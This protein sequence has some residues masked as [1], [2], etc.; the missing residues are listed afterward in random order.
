MGTYYIDTSS[1]SM[2]LDA[3]EANPTAENG[4]FTN[5]QKGDDFILVTAI[6]Y[7]TCN[8]TTVACSFKLQFSKNG[9]AWTD[10][11]AATEISY[12]ADTTLVDGADSVQRVTTNVNS[13][14]TSGY[15]VGRES[16]GDNVVVAFATTLRYH[17]DIH[18]ALST[19]N[20]TVSSVYTF[21]VINVTNSNTAL[22]GTIASSVTMAATSHSP[23]LSESP[24]PSST[25]SA[26]PSPSVSDSASISLSES[27]SLSASESASISASVSASISASLSPSISASI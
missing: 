8:K 4:S 19:D 14:C 2:L 1:G 10:V 11:G 24:T 6:S 5:W 26:S 15:Q 21:R 9:G 13:L 18:W 27:P 23:S 12:P 16:E 20:A 17:S 25:P 3:N 7:S 22:S